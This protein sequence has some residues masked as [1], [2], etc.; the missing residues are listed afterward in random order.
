MTLPTFKVIIAGGR[1]F[2]DYA[3]LCEKCDCILS[4]K[5]KSHSV[6]IVSG[7]A[8][9]AD[10]LGERYANERGYPI[11]RFRPDWKAA[12]RAAGFVR[13]AQM[14]DAADALIAFWDGQ[15]KG[16]ENMIGI[17]RKRNLLVRVV[18]YKTTVNEY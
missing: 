5:R 11:Q 10:S 15:S 9:G 17:A 18:G 16:T 7:T 12:G 13:N 4:Q 1:D 2:S 6:V 8:R 3:L 14:A